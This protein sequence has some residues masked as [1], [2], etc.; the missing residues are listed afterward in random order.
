VSEFTKIILRLLWRFYPTA[1]LTAAIVRG[2][3]TITAWLE[4]EESLVQLAHDPKDCA[5]VGGWL[6]LAEDRLNTLIVDDSDDFLLRLD[7]FDSDDSDDFS[8]W[9]DDDDFCFIRAAS[10]PSH[11]LAALARLQLPQINPTQPAGFTCET[12]RSCLKRSQTPQGA[13]SRRPEGVIA[14]RPRK[15]RL[16]ASGPMHPAKPAL[17]APHGPR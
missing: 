3:S 10:G 17:G 5:H 15:W 2:L 12:E 6:T 16:P 1:W 8:I 9:P 4:D 7:D 11:P 13:L 14:L